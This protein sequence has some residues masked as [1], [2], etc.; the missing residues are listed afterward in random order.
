MKARFRTSAPP[1]V[2]EPATGVHSRQMPGVLVVDI[3]RRIRLANEASVK[4]LRPILAGGDA[5]ALGSELP[6]PI[7]QLIDDI[8]SRLALGADSCSLML[9]ALDVCIRAC[10]ISGDREAHLMLLVERASRQDIV[11]SALSRYRLTPREAEVAALVLRG[12]SNRRIADSLVLTEY[13]VEDHLKR[14]FAK[15]GV[16]SRSSLASKILGIREEATG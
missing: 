8:E 6:V 16:R 14:I 2:V 13:T 15:V 10:V 9:P 4:M 3:A 1:L 12:F 5:F 7:R 11:R